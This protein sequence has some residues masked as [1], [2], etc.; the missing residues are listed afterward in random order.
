MSM[1][2]VTCG[3]T[4][5]GKTHQ[6]QRLINRDQRRFA[7]VLSVTTRQRRDA[8]DGVWYRF[9]TREELASF[10]PADVL[11]N[12]EFSG[13]RYVLLRSEIQKALEHAPIAF[14]AIVPS[15]ILLMREQ[16]VPHSLIRCRVGDPTGYEERLV[17]RGF[18]GDKLAKEKATGVGYE[19]PVSD[20]AWPEQD[21]MLGI[22]ATDDE[23]FDDAVRAL[24]GPLFPHELR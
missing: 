21:V 10:D 23:R 14:M 3:P 11:S 19:Y 15:V 1:L 2:I 17:K 18:T 13:E 6:M 16:K 7:P 20:A 5:I 8:E 24:A 4:G 22:D 9:I 12:V